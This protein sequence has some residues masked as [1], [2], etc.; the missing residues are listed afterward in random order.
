MATILNGAS[1][2]SIVFLLTRGF[3]KWVSLTL[4]LGCPAA[5]VIMKK[6]LANYAYKT[7]IS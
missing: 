2:T 7:E 4:I 6:I 1:V 5:W 3:T